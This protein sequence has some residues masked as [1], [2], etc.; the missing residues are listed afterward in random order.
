MKQTR[1]SLCI[2]FALAVTSCASL[3]PEAPAPTVEPA[4]VPVKLAPPPTAPISAETL[5]NLLVAELAGKSD[6]P[7]IALGNYLQEAHKTRDPA[8]AERA[9]QIARYLGAHQASLDAATLWTEVSPDNM[10]ARQ[11]LIVELIHANRSGEAQPYLMA[12]AEK[13]Q[14]NTFESLV[15]N[16]RFVSADERKKMLDGIKK[17][18]E[19][20]PKNGDAWF[21][22]ALLHEQDRDLNATLDALDQAV[23]ADPL[24]VSAA[25]AQGKMLIALKQPERAEKILEKSV[26]A[27]PDS[28]RLRLA[29]AQALLAQRKNKEARE[30]FDKLIEQSPD[31]AELILSFAA[32]SFESNMYEDA[33]RYSKKLLK[34]N[35]HEN[36]ARIYLAQCAEQQEHP[37]DAI[38]HYLKVEPG[39][40]F[41]A[42]RTQAAL[43]L[44]KQGKPDQARG[45]LREARAMMPEASQQLFV[46]ESELLVQ[47]KQYK[48]AFNL[49][50]DGL[51]QF[52]GD[53]NLLYSRSMV[54]ERLDKLDIVEQDLRQV[55]V[56][57]PKN[58][59]ALN[60][61]GYV[62]ADRT[63][64]YAEALDLIQQAYQL[65]PTD[66]AILDSMGWIQY[67]LGDSVKAL[68]FLRNAY[69]KMKDQEVAAHLG[70]VL[71][72]L[73]KHDEA[74]SVWGEA[75]KRQPDGEEL[76]RTMNRFLKP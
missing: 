18:N 55:L 72:T 37:D 28:K 62:L 70:E 46:T 23:K 40:Q 34:L 71:W 39:P 45:Y 2:A 56:G 24:H 1:L 51:S 38:K 50:T 9:A 73:G 20:Y 43:I 16:N 69:D 29:Y 61:L 12:M 44:F 19:S 52:P 54:A 14:P 64:R 15:I 53:G 57:N 48:D 32:V 17:V 31:D 11:T 35:Q 49:L 13:N 6:R 30:Q 4:A 68:D 67:R 22:R 63:T 26:A 74:K 7:D 42:A 10:Q 60:A 3:K 66:P 58:A 5:Y 36:E 33:E 75:Q 47:N 41:T 25:V 21:A 65:N 76:A 8:V 27:N 59:T